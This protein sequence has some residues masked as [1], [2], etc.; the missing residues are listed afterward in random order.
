MGRR[1][2][3]TELQK[4]LDFCANV[5]TPVTPEQEQRDAENAR[6]SKELLD[7]TETANPSLLEEA[8]KVQNAKAQ[9]DGEIVEM[10]ASSDS[11]EPV[12]T[13]GIPDGDARHVMK[14][15]FTMNSFESE[16]LNGFSVCISKG[17]LG[18]TKVQA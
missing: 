16:T 10:A 13:V 15:E 6:I 11:A 14:D 8:M 17:Q 4:S 7:K 5:F 18:L 2:S 9:Q 1:L 12:G 3:E